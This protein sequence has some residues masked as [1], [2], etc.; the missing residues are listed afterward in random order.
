VCV[1]VCDVMQGLVAVM[2]QKERLL[3]LICSCGCC[4]ICWE[5]WRERKFNYLNI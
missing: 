1:C 4:L 3:V 5:I 2:A